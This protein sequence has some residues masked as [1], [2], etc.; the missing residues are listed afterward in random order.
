MIIACKTR[1][2]Q[3]RRPYPGQAYRLNRDYAIRWSLYRQTANQLNHGSGHEDVQLDFAV[4]LAVTIMLN[5]SH[6]V[7]N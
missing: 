7:L 1:T 3:P 6:M 4:S 2:A 5:I